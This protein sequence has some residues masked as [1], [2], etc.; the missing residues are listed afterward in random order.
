M[1]QIIPREEGLGSHL[2]RVFGQGLGQGMVRHYE[3]GVLEQALAGLSAEHPPENRL[4]TLLSLPL[5]E[6][7]KSAIP[8]LQ[9][10]YATLDNMLKRTQLIE[11]E[12]EREERW[13]QKA[14]KEAHKKKS[15]KEKLGNTLQG[16][17]SGGATGFSAR[18]PVGA[19]VGGILGGGGGALLG[20]DAATNLA[21]QLSNTYSQKRALD[22]QQAQ[23]ER[24]SMNDLYRENRE[25]RLANDSL[26]GQIGNEYKPALDF[27]KGTLTNSYN[28]ENNKLRQK[29]Y[30]Q[31]LGEYQKN[32]EAIRK[33]DTS[34][35]NT[36]QL[37]ALEIFSLLMNSDE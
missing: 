6:E 31:L 14:W 28:Q 27:V 2:G 33:G 22:Q 19:V 10:K 17:L 18:G 15:I 35:I 1:V 37:E 16:I 3:K 25:S 36:R 26:A 32:L 7:T 29:Y 11:K 5:S 13:R 12:Q 34:G 4:A 24:S 23:M 9:E 20:G 8:L 21:Q 30:S